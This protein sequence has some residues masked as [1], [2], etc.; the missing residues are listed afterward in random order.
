MD[1]NSLHRQRK[2]I[3]I[4]ALVGLVSIFLPWRVLSSS[5]LGASESY[6][7]FRESGI[8]AFIAFLVVS[9][10]ALWGE[11]T[12]PL[13]KNLWFA[14]LIAGALAFIGAVINVA[15]TAGKGNGFVDLNI[16]FGCWLALVA[17]FVVIGAAWMLRASDQSLKDGFDSLKK[18][19]SSM[20]ASN[21]PGSPLG[22]S[23]NKVEELEKLARLK[24]EGHITE[25]EYERMKAKIL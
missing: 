6:N 9:G 4:A 8:L 14:I 5:F 1:F 3:L 25:E 11:Q 22:P 23:A 16:G 21:P 10:I 2:I 7:G 13:D 20:N 12:K 17:S 24:N 15:R 19:I 18:S